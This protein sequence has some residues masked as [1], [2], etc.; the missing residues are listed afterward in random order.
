MSTQLQ[1]HDQPEAVSLEQL[2]VTMAQSPDMTT[3][4]VEVLERLMAMMERR[5]EQRRKELFFEALARVQALVK[6]VEQNG[7][8]ARGDK[9]GRIPYAKRED[10][11]AMVKPIYIAEGFSVTW[12][13]PTSDDSGTIHVTGHF[14]C[15]G[16]TEI[17]QW[18]CKPDPSGG[19]TGPQ[20]VSSTIAYGKRQIEKMFWDVEEK[21]QD[22]NGAESKDIDPITENQAL[23]IRTRMNDLPQSRPGVLLEK[24]CAKYDVIKPE[25]LK[26][27]QYEAVIR[28]VEVTERQKAPK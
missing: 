12:D 13:A 21:G 9:G 15:H 3:Q 16:H 6:P 5:D 28:D 8:M 2:V 26:V 1:K 24:L 25:D 22:K 11:R 17:R 19:K 18:S 4:K 14:T 10:I 20:A 7:M 27:G 23:D